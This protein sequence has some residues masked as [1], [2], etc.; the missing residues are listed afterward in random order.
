MNLSNEDVQDILRV[1]DSTTYDELKLETARFSLMLRRSAGGTWTQEVQALAAAQRSDS[2]DRA[3]ATAVSA[4]AAGS[5]SGAGAIRTAG[6]P[7]PA[8]EAVTAGA[9]RAAGAAQHGLHEVRPPMLGTFYRAPKPG[10]APFVEVGSKVQPDSV[11]CIIETMKLM[12]SVCAGVA[13]EVVEIC[14]ADAQ[15]ADEAEV[16]LRIRPEAACA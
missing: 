6:A 2:A 15:F 12:N 9:V 4:G 8:N 16:L 5:V 14:L 13:G 7:G 11:V 10:A 3:V 1:L